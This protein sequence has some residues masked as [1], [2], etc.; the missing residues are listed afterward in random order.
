MTVTSAS[1]AASIKLVDIKGQ[2]RG[3]Q[4]N[5]C[6]FGLKHRR[7]QLV[8]RERR[9]RN[10]QP[11]GPVPSVTDRP[12]WISSFEPLPTRIPSS[13][14]PVNFARVLVVACR[15]ELRIP[16]PG[17]CEH[18]ID[19]FLLELLRKL[20]RILVLVQFDVGLEVLERVRGKT[21]GPQA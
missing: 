13:G 4:R 21:R 10:D 7:H 3:V 20:V 9:L 2:V 14:Q 5:G 11:C 19:D 15:N 6:H 8:E 12:A 18:T 16:A 17:P 1:C